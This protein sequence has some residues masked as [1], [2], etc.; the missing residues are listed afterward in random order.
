[1]VINGLF[2]GWRNFSTMT[3]DHQKSESHRQYNIGGEIPLNISPII[4][5]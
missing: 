1:M 5:I 3:G 2:P 4:E